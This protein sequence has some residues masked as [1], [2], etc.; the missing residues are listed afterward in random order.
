MS[1]PRTG[2]RRP[3]WTL[4][5]LLLVELTP[6]T[7]FTLLI[8]S[9]VVLTEDMLQFSDLV[10]N[11]GLGAGAVASL[12]LY[13]L[14]PAIAWMLPFAVLM[15][16]LI[17]LGR[18]GADRELLAIEAAGISAPRLLPPVLLF[19]SVATALGLGLSVY[20]APRANQAMD[21]TLEEM[22]Q[23]KP[24]A[25]LRAG[26]VRRFGDW[27]LEAREVSSEG[28]RL[29]GVQLWMP[30][31]GETAF[32]ERAT[33]D[34]SSG[35]GI[36]IT[37]ERGAVFLNPRRHARQLRFRELTAFL[38]TSG[39]ALTRSE[40]EKLAGL[41]M[42]ALRALSQRAAEAE[43]QRR[44]A[45]P[46]A[47]LVFGALAVP[48]FMCRA[49]F[50]RSGGL[51][52]GLAATLVY[53]GLVQLS[54][55]LIESGAVGPT[56]GVW[57]PDSVFAAVALALLLRLTRMSAVGRHRS[58]RN[59]WAGSARSEASARPRRRW[60]LYRCVAA[61]FV[62]VAALCFAG[63]LVAYLVVDVLERLERFASYE[64][65]SI[66]VFRY[67]AARIPLLASRV[68]PMSLLVA[69]AL[70]VSIFAAQGELIG[71][72]SCG[73]PAPRGLLPILLICA[74]IVP[75]YF[76]LNDRVIPRTNAFAE[77]VN[78]REIKNRPE[79]RDSVEVWY[80]EGN[81]FYEADLFDP[82]AGIARNITVYE[83]G[84]GGLPVS[85]A[86]A[87][88][89][90]HVGGG[91]WRLNGHVRVESHNGGVRR[92]PVSAFAR[93]GEALVSDRIDTRHLSVEE[94]RREIEDLRASGIDTTPFRVDLYVKLATPFACL[95][96]PALALF[97][98]LG[99]PPH[100]SPPATLVFSA[101]VAVGYTLLTGLG[102]GL[103]YGKMVVP[104]V[105]GIAPVLVFAAATGYLGLRLSVFR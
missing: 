84:P 1:L 76:L 24:W 68:I 71:M 55:G 67:Y 39:R 22:A 91:V 77:R 25:A 103:G 56:L 87:R 40:E 32:A 19:A 20:A 105:A 48:L 80:R 57:L 53:Y 18:L 11:R 49:R 51:L 7:L 10:L 31:L 100:P 21:A 58:L 16:S 42:A 50:S 63:V 72:R 52:L 99:G 27:K 15:G 44:F 47:V 83:I 97:F 23:R 78:E 85:R 62:Q 36:R 61:R 4:Y 14:V 26:Q 9:I 43:L 60:A 94:L 93:L 13:R 45:L 90:R 64:A 8:L 79:Q 28:D 2:H 41:T 92:V 98:S 34:R 65:S 38:P 6:P 88:W 29:G 30:D 37:L 81:S 89:G 104:A 59:L 96:L 95:V 101:I 54:N 46:A 12:A 66:E 35:E 73:V 102:T 70:T 75:V 33:L 74:A 3:G 86:D 5:R 17:A 82:D 69:T